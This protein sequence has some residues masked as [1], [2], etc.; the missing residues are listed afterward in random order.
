MTVPEPETV[1]LPGEVGDSDELDDLDFAE[2]E[3]ASADAFKVAYSG[4]DFDVEGLVRR[5]KRGDMLVPQF[6]HADERIESAGFQRNFVWSKPQMDRFIESLL[7]GYPIPSILLIKQPDNRYLI[8]DGQ[9]RLRTLQ[10]FYDG[11]HRDRPF[12]LANVANEFRGLSYTTLSDSQR[13]AI[14]NTYIQA[15]IV[16]T[17]GSAESQEAVYQI[18]ERLN[19]GGTQ[20]TSHEIRVALYAGPLIDLMHQLNQDKNWRAVYGEPSPRLRDQELVMRIIALY[21]DELRYMRPLKR[22]LNQFAAE[23]RNA[24][25]AKIA[26]AATLFTKAAELIAHG[27]GSEV[28]K[29]KSRQINVAQTEA[30]FVGIMKELKQRPLTNKQVASAVDL[31]RNNPDL[32]GVMTSGTSREEAVAA[33]LRGS[34]S[35]FAQV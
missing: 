11:Q 5:L 16:G 33:R 28:T 31:L 24:E 15:T 19:S 20:L 32:D 9:Q 17:D 18:F 3:E 14:D 27:P 23:N 22:F 13:R 12:V 21:C 34:A 8:L 2:L 25:S 1:D 4:Q 10:R 26:E 30:V 29:R 6:G 35:A 7:L